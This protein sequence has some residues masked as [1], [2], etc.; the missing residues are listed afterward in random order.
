M[1][2]TYDWTDDF[3]KAL[4]RLDSQRHAPPRLGDAAAFVHDTLRL[5]QVSAKVLFGG[6]ATPELALAVFDRI[7]ARQ[8]QLT[9]SAE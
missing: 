6:A 4:S 7:C 9:N 5:A 2:D 3:D 1:S 8:A